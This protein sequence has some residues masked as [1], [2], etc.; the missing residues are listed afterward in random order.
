MICIV[1]P[2]TVLDRVAAE[3]RGFSDPAFCWHWPRSVTALGYGQL[4]YRVDGKQHL[5]YAHRAA[6]MLRNG[7]IPSGMFVCHRCDNPRCFNPAHLFLGTSK[8]NQADMAAKGRGNR[9]KKLPV[10]ERH[11]TK[12]RRNEVRGSR[13]GNSRLTEGDVRVILA[14]TSS[15]A[16]LARL[17]EV[18]E[19]TISHIRHGKTWPHISRA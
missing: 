10:G 9:G 4:S 5:A 16:S 1:Y 3:L 8:E 12:S 17:Y 19:T 14:S 7:A 2:L 15:G 6:F 18:S 11:W 13:N